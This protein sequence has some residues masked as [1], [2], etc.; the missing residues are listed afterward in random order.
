MS[1]PHIVIMGA[2]ISGLTL[3]WNLMR[4]DPEIRLTILE[5][6]PKAGGWIRTEVKDGFLFEKGPH[7][8][9]S[10]GTGV[11]TLQLIEALGLQDQWIGAD[12][13]SNKRFIY[14]E[15][16]LTSLPSNPVSFLCSPFAKMSL[17]FFQE[18]F[19]EKSLLEDES[20]F[21]FFSRR[22]G[23][24]ITETFVDPMVSG[25]YAGDM[26]QLSMQSCFPAI[27]RYEQKH[28]SVFGAMLRSMIPSKNRQTQVSPFIIQARKFS[29]FSFRRGMGTL[30][31]ALSHHVKDSLVFDTVATSLHIDPHSLK[32]TLN[33]GSFIEADQLF[34][35]VPAE[36]A[37]SLLGP[38]YVTMDWK[39][40]LRQP[41]SVA[42]V[43][44]GWKR[45]VLKRKGFGYLVP[46][47]EK[48]DVLGVLWDSSVF[49][50]QNGCPGE[51]RMTVMLGGAHRKE[52]LSLPE[53][54]L[55]D[56]SLATLARHL[57]V[58][59]LPD[60]LDVTYARQAIAQYTVGHS[61]FVAKIRDELK[62]RTQDRVHL[63]G[64]AWDGVS[65]ND[66]IANALNVLPR[67]L[68]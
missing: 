32:I 12:L 20:V 55:I 61:Q 50:Q 62:I 56:I 51:T 31:D 6:E 35:A 11:Y 8:C 28:G 65:V 59:K 54:Q 53:R 58:D 33:N 3:G 47:S 30:I 45:D 40:Q 38:E 64:S 9:R 42:V 23:K 41:V 14:R 16:G 57:G 36:A 44:M 4:Q 24:E 17:R 39:G 5:K 22:F 21:D 34:L 48:E 43:N 19:I 63:L 10:G 15:N 46:T 13:K 67:A 49:P 52:L 68:P 60:A 2:G 25:I 37:M 18:W 27:H 7:S 1:R 29:I 26:R 66:C